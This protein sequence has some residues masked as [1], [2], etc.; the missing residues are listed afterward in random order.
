LHGRRD[1]AQGLTNDDVLTLQRC[2]ACG[3]VPSFP[4]VACPSCFEP[5]RAFAASGR[6]RVRT[7]AV[8]RRPHNERFLAHLPIVMALIELEEGSEVIST[9]V[10][11]NRLDT[12]I[13]ARVAVAR[14]GNWSPLV[15]FSLEGT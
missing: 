4:R 5:L 2:P 6:G 14:H 8:I 10:G 15:Q 9:I 11:E 13:D 3:H 7:Y 1:S 12:A